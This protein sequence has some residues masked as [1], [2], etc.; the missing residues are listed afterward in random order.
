MS[1]LCC[2]IP[3]GPHLPL[4]LAY[5]LLPPSSKVAGVV[6]IT[7]AGLLPQL[8]HAQRPRAGSGKGSQTAL[9]AHVAG[10]PMMAVGLGGGRGCGQWVQAHRASGSG[11]TA[12]APPTSNLWI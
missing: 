5:L 6:S 11:G 12:H 2:Q 7:G 9:S 8:V 3:M 4:P 1:E 10:K